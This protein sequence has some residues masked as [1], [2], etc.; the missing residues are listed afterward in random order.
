MR[1]A[2]LLLV[3]MLLVPS[4]A[5]QV[6]PPPS[7][8]EQ[9]HVTF[10]AAPGTLV[11]QWA[12]QG[13]GY[14]AA[15][16]PIVS[17]KIGN[18]ATNETAAAL[19]GTIANGAL[20]SQPPPGETFVYAATIGPAPP[21]STVTYRVGSRER[22]LTP[23]SEVRMPET[24]TLRFVAYGDIGYD[25]VAPDG[26]RLAGATSYAPFNVRDRV[27]A[28]KPALVVIPG[29]LSY[30]NS[31]SGWD[32]F[33]RFMEPL[34]STT[35]VMPVI[36]NHEWD[37]A[38]GYRQFLSEYVLPSANEEN[39]VFR[40]GPVTFIAMNSDRICG[41]SGRGGGGSPPRPCGD[42]DQ[43]APN[44]TSLAFLE[45]AL[46]QA[47][48]DDAPWTIVFHHHP[49]FSFG[50]HGSDWAVQSLWTPLF[51]KY[52]VD[53]DLTAH[54]HLYSRSHPLIER[55]PT[56]RNATFSKGAGIVYVVNG[57]GGRPLYDIPPGE[58]PS[59]HAA[60]G[61]LH[62]YSRWIVNETELRYEAVDASSGAVIDSFT[63]VASSEQ[64]RGPPGTGAP[65][66][67]GLVTVVMVALLVAAIRSR[68]R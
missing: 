54:D 20:N 6:P 25:G 40:A 50:R 59:W 22:G 32:R 13:I 33:M 65:A 36:G 5:A 30:A 67:G 44:Q 42:P 53:V 17:W 52:G 63:I 31:R 28:E 49:A 61:R 18:G 10:G 57:G 68:R 64:P 21:G 58:A 60:G 27:L 2:L 62:H 41:G 14:T 11:V 8:P 9:R 15:D 16:H 39:Y 7:Q 24:A 43:G 26:S 23:A 66:F 34:Q 35:V 51:E 38:L 1:V 12:L 29:D 37:G 46:K 47:S 48:E 19:S 3:V 4:T 56:A 45:E 55:E